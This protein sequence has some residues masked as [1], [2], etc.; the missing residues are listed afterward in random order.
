MRLP[1]DETGNRVF[2]REVNRLTV[3]A[4][5]SYDAFAR[6][7]QKEIEDETG[8]KFDRSRIG[9]ARERRRAALKPDWRLD[10]N[11]QALWERIKSRTRYA[12]QYS[13]EELVEKA[14][15]AIGEMPEIVAPRIITSKRELGLTETGVKA[16]LRVG[17][18]AAEIENVVTSLP[19]LLGYLQHETELTRSTLAE[20]LTKSGRLADALL[21][22]QQFL[23]S[24]TR[25]IRSTLDHL[26]VEGIKYERL[27][28][29][30][31]EMLLFEEKE[32]NGYSSRMVEVSKSIYDALEYD[33]AVEAQF[34]RDLDSRDDIKLFVKLPNWF[35]IETPIGTYNPDWAIV[36]QDGDG[37]EKLYLVRETKG[38]ENL[39]DLRPDERDK[40]LCGTAHF[41]TLGVNYKV[42]KDAAKV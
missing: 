34:A 9:N 13:T 21:N 35:K 3:I 16:T 7:L 28:D 5:E 18:R 40:I 38:T 2:D 12:V 4:N 6:D 36:K 25:A 39:D 27:G 10:P 22:P 15:K 19:D 41:A 14:A 31:Y 37:E 17:E 11:F 29:A 24:A 26:M 42:V 8:E 20:I 33:S 23:D 32:I 30:E 1:V